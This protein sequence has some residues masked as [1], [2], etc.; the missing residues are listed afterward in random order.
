IGGFADDPDILKMCR[1]GVRF[2]VMLATLSW[3][4][5]GAKPLSFWLYSLFGRNPGQGAGSGDAGTP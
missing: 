5:V 1:H 4:G 2:R 3:R